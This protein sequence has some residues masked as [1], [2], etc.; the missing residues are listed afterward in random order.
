MVHLLASKAGIDADG[1]EV[2]RDAL[3][4][5]HQRAAFGNGGDGEHAYGAAGEGARPLHV[6]RLDFEGVGRFEAGAGAAAGAHADVLGG[7][8][9]RDEECEEENAHG[10]YNTSKGE[11]KSQKLKVKSGGGAEGRVLGG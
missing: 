7:G 5:F 8:G 10:E 9:G 11:V 3:G 1:G 6:G 2:E 4:E